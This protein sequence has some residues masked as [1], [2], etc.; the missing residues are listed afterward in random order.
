MGTELESWRPAFARF[1]RNFIAMFRK[2]PP[3]DALPIIRILRSMILSLAFSSVLYLFVLAFITPLGGG[4]PTGYLIIWIGWTFV[5]VIASRV[6]WRYRTRLIS[7]ADEPRQAV[8]LYQGTILGGA[9]IALIPAF[10]AMVIVLFRVGN[11]LPV[12]IGTATSLLMAAF[13]APRQ[14]GVD[15]IQEMIDTN[16]GSILLAEALMAPASSLK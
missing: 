3:V 9:V 6:F 10:A 12:V 5:A 1:A 14:S 11:L 8:V 16:G 4:Y 13:A 15:R 2:P 7:Q